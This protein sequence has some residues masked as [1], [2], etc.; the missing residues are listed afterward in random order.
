[1]LNKKI[2][3]IVPVYNAEQYI[4][5]TIQALINQSYK[6]LEIILV[7]NNSID[8]SL[9]ICEK[10]A[11]L[12][13]RIQI[14]SENISGPSAARNKGINFATGDFICFCDS[15]DLPDE[16]MYETLL[17]YII[18][19]KSDITMCEFYSERIDDILELPYEDKYILEREEILNDLIPKMIGNKSDEE[20]NIPIWGSVCRCIY[21]KSIIQEMN[22]KF[23]ED[24]KFAE[25][26]IF[27]LSYLKNSQSVSICK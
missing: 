6:N 13:S 27:T 15:D 3:I 7:D 4:E 16:N 11:E 8:K 2:S 22:L 18:G 23:N 14:T 19:L 20:K 5:R 25:D 17:K 10:Y 26:L 1:M 21:K 9:E 24:I 12:D